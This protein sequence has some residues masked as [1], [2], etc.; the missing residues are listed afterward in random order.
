MYKI[1]F[2]VLLSLVGVAFCA[3]QTLLVTTTVWV[4]GVQTSSTSYSKTG[5][6]SLTIQKQVS[7]TVYI[8]L[9]LTIANPTWVYV[10]SDKR[11]GN[12]QVST[13]QTLN[14]Q[15]GC[16]KY[17]PFFFADTNSAVNCDTLILG[18]IT[19]TANVTVILGK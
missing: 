3:T 17:A 8:P 11:I 10:E 19:D 9:S 2:F 13:T 4:N 6:Q 15:P 12:I 14:K 16:D 5:V 18:N 1:I 7:G